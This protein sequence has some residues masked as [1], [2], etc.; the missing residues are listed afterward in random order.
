MRKTPALCALFSLGFLFAC[1]SQTISGLD[2]TDQSLSDAVSGRGGI[3]GPNKPAPTA[4]PVGPV[5]P[6][7]GPSV[8][9][10]P[11]P[12]ATPTGNPSGG[13][14]ATGSLATGRAQAE[15]VRLGTKVLVAGGTA[16]I[17]SL[18]ALSS[19]EVFDPTTAS[20]NSAGTMFS[21]RRYHK[22]TALSDSKALVTGGTDPNVVLKSAEIYTSGSGWTPTA[23]MSIVRF[24]HAA[25]LLPTN[26]KVLVAG[27]QTAGGSLTKSTEIFDPQTSAWSP[28]AP[29]NFARGYFDLFYLTKS[30]KVL[31]VGIAVDASNAPR[32]ET[33]I[34]DPETNQWT[35]VGSLHV[36][37]LYGAAVVLDDHRVLVA[38]GQS[39]VSPYYSTTVTEIFDS[40]TLTWTQL[41]SP[42][43]RSRYSFA[44]A[45]L[46]S[47]KVLSAGGLYNESGCQRC[48]TNQAEIFD[49]QTLLWTSTQNMLVGSSYDHTMTSL[50]DGGVLAAGGEANGVYLFWRD[51][52]IF[53]EP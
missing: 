13:W 53:H 30:K 11:T 35:V 40:D 32:L 16:Y 47:G 7:D 38:G 36:F 43:P 2:N 52:A 4:I 26:G 23:D 3:P 19:S 25:V 8:T 41:T 22:L 29:M 46:G 51:A 50:A 15:A 9:P 48:F 45:L 42:M 27:G 39:P 20:W 6:T 18:V 21:P 12:T 24:R 33:E 5:L 37:H 49:P 34:Y 10:T 17:G 14:S 28:A 1:G 44:M 31:A